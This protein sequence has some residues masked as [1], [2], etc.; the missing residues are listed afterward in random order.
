M[1]TRK[2]NYQSY[3]RSEKWIEKKQQFRGSGLYRDGRCFV[4]CNHGVET[5]VH[6]M[7]YKRLG[8]E[9]LSDLRLLCFV[10]HAVVHKRA[11]KKGDLQTGGMRSK[12]YRYANK[13]RLW[14]LR[15]QDPVAYA[16]H[17]ARCFGVTNDPFVLAR[18][19]SS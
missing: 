7:T 4:C 8:R 3:I 5:H 18:K 9:H 6:H 2:V 17:V 14:K 10:C 13:R 1:S 19:T 15:Y 12:W 11:K 16:G